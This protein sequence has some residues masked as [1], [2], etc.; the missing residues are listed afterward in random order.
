[1]VYSSLTYKGVFPTTVGAFGLFHFA[2]DGVISGQPNSWLARTA[3]WQARV[4]SNSLRRSVSARL[5]PKSRSSCS[6]SRAAASALD[7]FSIPGMTRTA[8]VLVEIGAMSKP[9]SCSALGPAAVRPK[10]RAH[11]CGSGG[12][13]AQ[14][15]AS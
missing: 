8:S 11:L 2:Q 12:K 13:V 6:T 4:A 10:Q 1:M 14:L 3:E 7:C 9:S 5:A 15:D